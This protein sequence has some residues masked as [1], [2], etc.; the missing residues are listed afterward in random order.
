MSL[1]TGGCAS[2]DQSLSADW[3]TFRA[4]LLRYGSGYVNL[5]DRLPVFISS[6]LGLSLECSDGEPEA[7]SRTLGAD[8]FPRQRFTQR[9]GTSTVWSNHVVANFICDGYRFGPS[10]HAAK[11]CSMFRPLAVDHKIHPI[12]IL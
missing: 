11:G 5:S 10:R 3:S 6:Y 1:V 12:Y 4:A 7:G 2:C 9:A 8:W